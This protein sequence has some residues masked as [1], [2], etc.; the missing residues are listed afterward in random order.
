MTYAEFKQ[1]VKDNYNSVFP[2]SACTISVGALG[3]DSAY[4]TYY[5]AG[6]QS[7][8][9]NRI[10]L[11]DLFDIT[12]CVLQDGVGYGDGVKLEDDVEMPEALVLDINHKSIKTAP[13]SK[14]MAY[15][16]VSLPFRK[17]KGT[18]EKITAI[19][20][21]YAEITKQT[22]TELYELEKLPTNQHP[23]VIEFVKDKLGLTESKDGEEYCDETNWA[24]EEA[25]EAEDRFERR[26]MNGGNGFTASKKSESKQVNNM[27]IKY[28]KMYDKYDVITPDGRVW[29]E[30]DTE[31]EAIDWASKQKDFVVK[32]EDI[33][34][35]SKD[36]LDKIPNDYKTT[37]GDTIKYSWEDKDM[38]RKKYK[39]LGY[40]ETDPMI[41]ARD[42][43]LGTVLK[44]VKVKKD[45]DIGYD[46]WGPKT[47]EPF[48]GK[49]F[50][51]YYGG[52]RKYG[53]FNKS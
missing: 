14:Y 17:T 4:I 43:K 28:D 2:N 20:K 8:F 19:L 46:Y 7:E 21:R 47:M 41:L 27:K 45:E 44:P 23:E 31:E 42:D 53:I 40:E 6:D 34:Y 51:Q 22:L 9:P 26:Y 30:F 29:E 38:L 25:S 39:D 16:S 49:A 12:F 24:E 32:K 37:V 35:I 52:P 5:L 18:P 13:E 3:R 11:N 48:E 15:S 10:A 50:I 36:E 1:I 33:D